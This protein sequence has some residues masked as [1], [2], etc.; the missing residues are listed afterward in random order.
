[1]KEFLKTMD[2]LV[3]K[4]E[5]VLKHNAELDLL[6]TDPQPENLAV[7]YESGNYISHTDSKKTFVDKLYQTVKEYSLQKKIKLI[8]AVVT[9]KKSLLDVGA[10]T[11]DFLIAAKNKDWN[12]VGVEPSALARKRAA[13]KGLDL[14]ESLE[15][16]PNEKFAVITLWHVLEHL[17]DLDYQ[18]QLLKSKLEKEGTLIVAVPN[19]KSYDANYYKQFWAAYDVPRHL[20]HFSKTAIERIFAKHQ[21]TVVK[22]KPMLFDAFYV[23]LLS[24]KYKSGGQ[25][26][27]GAFYRGLRSNVSA[28][29]TKEHSSI[30]YIIKNH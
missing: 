17:P 28:M 6:V 4:E 1:M 19:F 8:T 16:L 7:Y 25:N 20:W 14:K 23:S 27:I 22:T 24:E 12:I 11:G 2:Y 18:I 13:A 21:M 9:G 5:F 26:L 15:T 3:S 10:G 29:R 30:I